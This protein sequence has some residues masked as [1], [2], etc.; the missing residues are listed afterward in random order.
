MFRISS[1]VCLVT[2]ALPVA[3]RQ[4]EP[5]TA[6]LVEEGLVHLEVAL[7]ALECE[8][9]IDFD[10]RTWWAGGWGDPQVRC[11]VVLDGGGDGIVWL[12]D[13]SLHLE[14][15]AG[16]APSGRMALPSDWQGNATVHAFTLPEDLEPGT[17]ERFE[18][19]RGEHLAALARAGVPGGAWFRHH[20]TR[21]GAELGVELDPEEDEWGNRRGGTDL[22]DTF[23]L[24]LG[25][26]AVAENLQLDRLLPEAQGDGETVKLADLPGID[27][28]PFDWGPHLPA[29]APEL[30]PLAM[31]VPA[32]QHAIF[33]PTFAAYA[34][35]HEELGRQ[36]AVADGLGGRGA[37]LADVRDR[38]QAQLAL[39]WNQLI[40]AF[41]GKAIDSV[42]ITGSDPYLPTGTD[43][44]VLFETSSPEE[45]LGLLAG[46]R[47]QAAPDAQLSEGD[48]DGVAWTG[49]TTPGRGVS[50]YAAALDGAVVVT[51]SLHQLERIVVDAP[52]APLAGLEEYVFFRDRY[53]I[54][55]ESTRSLA[56]ISDET[57]R[58]WCGPRWRIA[59]S[60][61]VR[62]AALMSDLT[63]AN[64]AG[65][66]AGAEREL[67]PDARFPL[68]DLALH[69]TGGVHSSMYG[70]LAFL[71]PIAEL[72]LE[73]VWAGEAQLYERW[74]E[75]YQRNWSN[76]FDPIAVEL[77]VGAGGVT[78]DLTVMPLITASDYDELAG[79]TGSGRLAAGA[80]DPHDGTLF[81]FAM[82]IGEDS[83]TLEEIR[84]MGRSMLSDVGDD[85]LAWL[86]DHA[87]VYLDHDPEFED[88]AGQVHHR[89]AW[90]GRDDG[91]RHALLARGG[92][93]RA[94]LRARVRGGRRA[95]AL[96]RDDAGRVDPQPEPRGDRARARPR[97]G[98]DRGRVRGPDHGLGGRER[99]P[100]G[101][102]YR[103]RAP[104]PPHGGRAPRRAARHL[105]GPP[106]D[107]ER[108]APPRARP[109]PGGAARAPV[110]REPHLPGRRLVRLER[111]GRDDGVECLRLAPVPAR[112][113]ARAARLRGPGA[114]LVRAQLRARR[115]ARAGADG[116]A[117]LIQRVAVRASGAMIVP[118]ATRPATPV[119]PAAR[120][121]TCPSTCRPAASRSTWRTARSA[122]ARWSC[123]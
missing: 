108:V 1:A 60:R 79:L 34:A 115:P 24:F 16:Q 58:R 81:H 28:R 5:S 123:A 17:A 27:V 70:S 68:G 45:L 8:P 114:P 3:A 64:V 35:H 25:G 54:D 53:P 46:L 82:A 80:G 26:R 78:A 19:A 84:S 37:R 94:S 120:R 63:A 44:A 50:T 113:R 59:A 57:I 42:A 2:L 121:S 14:V 105:L 102:R 65:V 4:E 75:G 9:P 41:G 110:G 111:I 32:D 101:R 73:T 104:R 90:D 23:A 106:P 15:P 22:E 40:R 83:Q 51:N 7:T 116:T 30:D 43:L 92:R 47:A 13:E 49:A 122:A 61:R 96:L 117:G 88:A 52:E 67:E 72:D 56:V 36:E 10:N 109:R 11:L 20:A 97:G 38:Y 12:E 74:R 29:E 107:P 33:F 95:R 71:T 100:R 31:L 62:A 93:G 112:G 118:W 69:G 89:R 85:P 6:P 39:P 98:P 21:I 66:L 119:P 99:G 55:R 103:P 86:G 87:A 91:A 18:R 48:V 76:F 77:D